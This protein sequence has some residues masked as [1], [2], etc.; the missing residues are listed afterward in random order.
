MVCGGSWLFVVVDGSLR[1]FMVV[2]E[3]MC[4]SGISAGAGTTRN[5]RLHRHLKRSLLVGVSI[6]SYSIP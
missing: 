1:L 4:L 6:I 3:Q 2:Y 5:E